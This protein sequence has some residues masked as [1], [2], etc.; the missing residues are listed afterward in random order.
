MLLFVC[1][2]LLLPGSSSVC[3][4]LVTGPKEFVAGLGSCLY[5]SCRYK[6]CQ[7]G[8]NIKFQ[9]FHWLHQPRYDKTRQDFFGEKTL[10][11][12]NP[13]ETNEG[14]CSLVL[15][16]LK[17]EDAGVY[18]LRVVA[19]SPQWIPR[20]L[21]WMHQ[22]TVNVTD[23]APAPHLWPDPSPLT[24]GLRTTLGCWVPP[25]CPKDTLTLTWEDPSPNIGGPRGQLDPPATVASFPGVGTRLE[26]EPLW[27]H[28]GPSSLQAF[29]GPTEQPSP[30][31]PGCSRSTMI[32]A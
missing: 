20:E 13:P 19:T 26:F 15:P 30:G 11:P 18:G 1:F 28:D 21:R 16:H 29:G 14:D 27:Y 32:L 22:V 24:Q 12:S 31:R 4:D 10:N 25:A 3:P 23:T 5:I 6:F 9:K 17:A 2:L 8:K 7:G